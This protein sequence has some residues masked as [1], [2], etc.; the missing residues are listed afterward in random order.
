MQF[1]ASSRDLAGASHATPLAQ[2]RV[3]L[4]RAEWRPLRPPSSAQKNELHPYGFSKDIGGGEYNRPILNPP[5]QLFHVGKQID[6]TKGFRTLQ[7]ALNAWNDWK[8]QHPAPYHGVIEIIDNGVY[9]E[10]LGIYLEENESLQI[11]AANRKRPVIRLVDWQG[12]LLDSLNVTGRRGS[13]FT[14]DGLLITGRGVQVVGDVTG[15]HI[16]H[17]TLVPGWG[18]RLNS[19][20][21][22]YKPSEPSLELFNIGECVTIEHSILG[23]ILAYENEAQEEPMHILIS[24]S[25]LDATDTERNA[26]SGEERGIAYGVLTIARST[27]FGQVRVHAIKLA[28]NSIFNG[29]ITVARR[30]WGCM[31]FC[32]ITPVSRTPRRYRCQ[33][34]LVEQ[35][36]DARLKKKSAS[37]DEKKDYKRREQDRVR[38]RFNNTRYGKSTYCR[39]SLN[40]AVEIAHGADD[41]SE[42]GVFH[43]LFQPQREANLR[44]RLD[45]YTPAGIEVGII[46]VS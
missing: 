44:A 39:L 29:I 2:G 20:G 14:L 21:E 40:C 4:G 33:P 35:A 18:L 27:V 36:A 46:Y 9:T 10:Q 16:R 11:R 17:C 34:D 41:E 12:N 7:D 26:L 15:V 6:T 32:Y 28:E 5:R 8:G 3:R 19:D 23:S 42:M 45:D 43:D 31:H 22:P 1:F 30:Q 25:I 13:R 37:P 24:D 38:P